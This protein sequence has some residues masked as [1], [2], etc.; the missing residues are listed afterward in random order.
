MGGDLKTVAVCRMDAASERTWMT[1]ICSIQYLSSMWV[2]LKP[3]Q[4]LNIENAVTST[5]L[6]F[7]QD[8]LAHKGQLRRLLDRHSPGLKTAG[9]LSS[10]STLNMASSRGQRYMRER[11]VLRGCWKTIN[12]HHN[13][14]VD[15]LRVRSGLW[16][17]RHSL[18]HPV[19]V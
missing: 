11:G 9:N 15:K 16:R 6:P 13:K 12:S 4:Y 10:T 19:L 18:I 5:V 14:A 3:D 7:K 8:G 2:V 17:C 1:D